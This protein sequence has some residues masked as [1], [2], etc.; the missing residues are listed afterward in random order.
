MKK[1]YLPLATLLCITIAA[2]LTVL[3][4]YEAISLPAEALAAIR[5][6]GTAVLLLYGL[7]KRSLTTWILISMVVGA[8]IGYDFPQV[9]QN[10]NVLS[11]VFLKL[12]KTII[13]PLI[14][15]TL[16]VGIAGHANLKQ[17]GSMGWKAI[18]YFEIV[19]TLALFIGLAAINI[20]KAGEGIN[21]AGIAETDEIQAPVK[22]TWADI[23]LHVFPENIA[24]SIAEGQVL[25]IVVFSV[26]FAI[27]LAMVSENKRK[28][29][30]DF[31]ES[32]SE[33]MFKFTNIIMYFAP[34]G[35]GAAIAYT[36]GHMGFGILVNL[37]QLLATLYVALLA[38]VL[39]V[40]L[41]VALIARIP[42]VRFLKA[43]SGP[44]SIAFATTSSEAALP[45][46]MEEMEKLGVPRRIVAFVMPT[47]YSFNLDGTTLYLALA[48]VFVAQAA[49]IDLTWEQQLLM[50][51]TLMLTSKGVAGVPRA[52]L[53][54]LLGTVA[55]FNL[56]VWPLFAILGID[57]LMDM[58]RTSINVTGNCLATAVVA[59]WE[60]EFDP[61]PEV[62]LVET[63]NPELEV[64]KEEEVNA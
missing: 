43:I 13:A 8:Q 38:F 47:G 53:V 18:L 26:I 27:G 12:I 40:L 23:I 5:W 29:M 32:L 2:I 61:Q 9:A 19:T 64:R 17:I 46:A 30:L 31:C 60:G 25:Q 50:V 39:L 14:F 44:V 34:I 15:A 51:F 4:Q 41:P 1:A 11:K 37:F 45:R 63:T 35:V 33:T 62:G 20:S 55:S 59:R 7:Q 22:Q 48:A 21:M 3:Q 58:A 56:P 6:T 52:S 24:K 49:G 36:V 42:I 54:I 28:P 10:L 16:V 57:E